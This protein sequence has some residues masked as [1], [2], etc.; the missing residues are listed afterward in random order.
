[1]ELIVVIVILA[2]LATI[3]FLSFSSQSAWARDSTRLSDMSNIAKWLSVFNAMSGK[4]PKPDNSININASWTTIRFQW[5]AGASV[6]NMIKIS[7][8]WKDPLDN[9]TY[10]TY[11]VN[12]A[13]NKFQILG[14]LE[15][16]SSTA[17]SYI[18]SLSGE[19]WWE[20]RANADPSSYSGRYVITKWDMLGILLQSWSL[21]PMQN[22]NATID[23]VKTNSWNTFKAI[24]ANESTN[25]NIASSWSSI[26]SNMI[27]TNSDLV[28]DKS[29]VWMDE[30]LVWYWDME[31]VCSGWNC[32][33]WNDWKLKDLSKYWNNWT[34]SWITVWGV[35]G[36]LWKAT[37]FWVSYGWIN[38]WK[39]PWWAQ[40]ETDS[41][42]ISMYA[43]LN[44]QIPANWNA[45]QTIFSR[46][47]WE[48]WTENCWMWW[49][50]PTNQNYSMF[51]YYAP[52]EPNSWDARYTKAVGIHLN[53]RQIAGDSLVSPRTIIWYENRFTFITVTYDW[54]WW[55]V[56]Y[57]WKLITDKFTNWSWTLSPSRWFSWTIIGA[58]DVWL[59]NFRAESLSVHWK[60]AEFWSAIDEVRLYNR[61]LSA[62]EV[63]NL[64]NWTKQ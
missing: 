31:S 27:N 39:I 35:T 64:Y 9:S 5:Y 7:N 46:Y 14:F 2:I 22:T 43:N 11:S 23:L 58:P 59:W 47:C 33:A 52:G 54:N 17:L 25:A 49:T 24:F 32:G 61:P 10:Y 56:Y 36:V 37:N 34:L 29:L 28:K 45:Y 42:T 13:Q 40:K 48:S 6:L 38:V 16:G 62:I 21:V 55:K 53:K 4:L 18:P 51:L 44:W 26:L 19:G 3:A 41:F 8:W 57:D 12:A 50:T 1:V 30:S 63:S 20:G 60:S 15:D